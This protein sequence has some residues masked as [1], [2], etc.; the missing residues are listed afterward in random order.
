MPHKME[1]FQIVPLGS[2]LRK[3]TE[4]GA[5]VILPSSMR[6]LDISALTSLDEGQLRAG[7][8]EHQILVIRNQEGID[9]AMLPRLARIFD[10]T[11]KDIHSGGKNQVTDEK[12]ILSQ[13]NC[14]RIPRAPQ[15]TVIGSGNTAGHEGLQDLDLKHVVSNTIQWKRSQ[16][17]L[18]YRITRPSIRVPCQPK[19][20]HRATRDLSMHRPMKSL[21]IWMRILRNTQ[22][23]VHG[24]TLV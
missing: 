21:G 5:E 20:W 9:P 13:N 22:S 12:N 10:P 16:S 1:N 18:V 4:L 17:K 3:Q 24:C 19:T 11:L 6:L 7:L 15:V 23:M 14:S 2:G 8:F